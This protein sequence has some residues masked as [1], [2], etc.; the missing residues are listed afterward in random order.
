MLRSRLNKDLTALGFIKAQEM[1]NSCFGRLTENFILHFD[2]LFL[3]V[4]H[5][6]LTIIVWQHFFQIKWNQIGK[7]MA[8]ATSPFDAVG[9]KTATPNY[10]WKRVTPPVEFG[11]MH[12][13]LFQMLLIPLTMSKRLLAIVST[14]GGGIGR[15][16]PF[17]DVVGFHIFLGYIF[18]W[19][20]LGSTLLFVIFFGKLCY[21]FNMGLDKANLCVKF[22][23]EIF[24][25]GLICLGSTI[26]VLITS[27]NRSRIKYES[28]YICHFFVFIMFGAATIHTID[29]KVRLHNLCRSQNI[30][31]FAGSLLVYATSKFWTYFGSTFKCKV[32]NRNIKGNVIV[33][34]VERP[35]GFAFH[36]GQSARLRIPEI[37]PFAHPFSIASAPDS[38]HLTF[39]IEVSKQTNPSWTSKL[40]A[41]YPTSILVSGP[42]GY[43]V[44]NLQDNNAVLAV[45]TGTGVV[46]MLSLFERRSNHL[47]TI[48]KRALFLSAQSRA[49]VS[50]LTQH[51]KISLSPRKKNL[52]RVFTVLQLQQR[53][54]KLASDGAD[55]VYFRHLLRT[56]RGQRGRFVA[57]GASWVLG[58]LEVVLL[59]ISCSWYNL[60]DFSKAEWQPQ[61]IPALTLVVLVGY[62]VHL[63]WRITHP[64]I[65]PRDMWALVDVVFTIVA[66]VS[67]AFWVVGEHYFATAHSYAN[68]TAPQQ[69]MRL[70]LGL[71]R[72]GRLLMYRALNTRVHST[73]ARDILGTERFK[74]IWVTHE[75]DLVRSYVSFLNEMIETAHKA[76]YGRSATQG[77]TQS[78]GKFIDYTIFVTDK[79]KKAC[80][81]LRQELKGTISEGKVTFARP[82][83]QHEVVD[84]KRQQL[85]QNMTS[86]HY[87]LPYTTLVTFCGNPVVAK[88]CARAVLT[89]NHL[90]QVLGYPQFHSE[91]RQQFHGH[92]AGQRIKKKKEADWQEDLSASR[93][94]IPAEE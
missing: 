8:N 15:I 70:L 26:I 41:T 64:R 54:K 49:N 12:Q 82:D 74:L 18:C 89:S 47:R 1:S 32:L 46:P 29:I 33:L 85:V 50:H 59:G 92:V 61:T 72:I 73:S 80:D 2:T 7:K 52:D 63:L 68:P 48:G 62:V 57:D 45:G 90:S 56:S 23:E 88:L 42:F 16:F 19:L 3:R 86:N 40:A 11:M 10:W 9:G 14:R 71:Y 6:L 84:F 44:A 34:N 75:A 87:V 25:T 66:V 38:P 5:I 94:E 21:D 67:L 91:F 77:W 43:P 51:K 58:V 79:N 83:L 81:Q 22:T 37:D 24:I 20:L 69:I 17:A 36:A 55:S 60:P 31:W 35:R 13:L 27:I 4:V 28:F 65:Y 39:V 53:L 76:L 93:A 78:L 30:Q